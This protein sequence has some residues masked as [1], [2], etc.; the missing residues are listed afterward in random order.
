MAEEI[1]PGGEAKEETAS[2]TQSQMEE[3][4][5]KEETEAE[6]AAVTPEAQLASLQADL[7]AKENLVKEYS[8]RLL[9]L[10]ADFENFRRRTRQEKE[11]LSSV[12]VQ[13]LIGDL[14]PVIDNLERALAAATADG[15]AL[16]TG[17]DMVYKQLMEVL[18]K[19]GLEPIEAVGEKFDPNFHQAVMRQTSEEEED[20]VL[21]ELQRG[22]SVRG[23]VVRPSMVKVASH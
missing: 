4:N 17:V 1:K 20:T 23:K 9:R 16:R 19:N 13:G 7:E 3:E 10:Q 11:D 6:A 12:V 15:E 18:G 21:E 2:P 8:D 22:Y 14:L 5:P